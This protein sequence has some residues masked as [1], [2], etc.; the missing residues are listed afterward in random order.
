MSR[1]SQTISP[2]V[3]PF[4]WKD[5]ED[6][7]VTIFPYPHSSECIVIRD[8]GDEFCGELYVNGIDP[9][10]RVWKNTRKEAF[11]CLISEKT[12]MIENDSL[13]QLIEVIE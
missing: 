3:Y 7:T 11:I 10:I 9:Y 5:E 4:I 12:D 8:E 13:K 6:H 1:S 2:P